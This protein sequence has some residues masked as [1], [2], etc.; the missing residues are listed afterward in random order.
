M[1]VVAGTIT[2]DPAY[3]DD[4]VEAARRVTEPTRAE[5]GCLS[6]ELFADLT[7]PGR[8]HVFE[9][10]EE[11][12]YWAAHL[13]TPHFT[14]YAAFLQSCGLRDRDISRYYVSKVVSNRPA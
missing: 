7:G 4:V 5:E 12:H 13:E 3:H 8:L 2:Y 6:Y 14:E 10:W 9:E 11:E 1:L